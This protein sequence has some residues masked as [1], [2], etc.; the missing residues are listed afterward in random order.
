ML[1][2]GTFYTA[3]AIGTLT[4]FPFLFT[5]SLHQ[6][7]H[8]IETSYNYCY[9]VPMVRLNIQSY[10]LPCVRTPL[11]APPPP[12][13]PA[14]RSSST[15]RSEWS[16]PV[17]TSRKFLHLSGSLLHTVQLSAPTANP[18]PCVNLELAF[19][20]QPSLLWGPIQYL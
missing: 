4:T 16:R 12:P 10:V 15:L 2:R 20:P 5:K 13:S 3:K 19:F 7:W 18:T 8:L 14:T 17:R 6:F 9:S 1:A 11:L